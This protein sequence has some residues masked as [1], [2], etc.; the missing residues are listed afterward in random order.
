MSTKTPSPVHFLPLLNTPFQHYHYTPKFTTLL[1]RDDPVYNAVKI[2][3]AEA[4]NNVEDGLIREPEV[5]RDV[6]KRTGECDDEEDCGGIE[7]VPILLD[8]F[9]VTVLLDL[10]ETN[11]IHNL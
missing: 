6:A 7:H 5:L 3:P 11:D 2:L 10:G 4:T 9:T 1:P 8:Y